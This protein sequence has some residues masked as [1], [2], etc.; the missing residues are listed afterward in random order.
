MDH[1]PQPPASQP[2]APLSPQ[3]ILENKDEV[4]FSQK[5]RHHEHLQG[6]FLRPNH[7]LHYFP[8]ATLT[9]TALHCRGHISG[10]Q[11]RD[12]YVGMWCTNPQLPQHNTLAYTYIQEHW[13]SAIPRFSLPPLP[14]G[15]TSPQPGLPSL[16]LEMT[17]LWVT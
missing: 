6:E 8:E 14:P 10:D 1:T 4:R 17:L 7:C 13:L 15:I 2:S 16:S 5:H 12:I 3:L 11:G 9:E